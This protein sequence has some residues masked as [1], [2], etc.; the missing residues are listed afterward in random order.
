M[1]VL[2]KK[3]RFRVTPAS[4]FSL[5]LLFK[6]KFPIVYFFLFQEKTEFNKA[7]STK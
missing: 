1:P 6:V 2:K 3:K 4:N 5:K 7:V